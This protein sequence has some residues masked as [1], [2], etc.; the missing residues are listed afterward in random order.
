MEWREQPTEVQ[1]QFAAGEL[2]AFETLFR[3]FQADVYGWIVRIV[4]DPAAAEDL[5]VETFWRIYRARARF[6]PGRSFGAWARRIATNVALDY[7]KSARMREQPLDENL[8]AG[9]ALKTGDGNPAIR[10]EMRERTQLAFRQ[11]PAKLRVVA[12]LALIEERPHSEIADALNI[13]TAAVKA[14]LFRAVRLLR[15]KLGNLDMSHE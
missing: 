1:E 12:T 8:A 4:R 10:R 7:L 2:E 3:Q 6:N 11:L 5:T 14:R 15:R 9:S 13:S